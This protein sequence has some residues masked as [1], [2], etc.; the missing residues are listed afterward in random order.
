ML[1]ASFSGG[2]CAGFTAAWPERVGR[3]VLLYPLMDYK[4]R[5]IDDK[6]YWHADYLDSSAA[7]EL[8]TRGFLAHS[9]TFRLGRPLLN[10]VF[11]WR[12]SE[13]LG[14]VA[15]PTLLVHGTGDTFIPVDSSRRAASQLRSAQL[16][17]IENAQH[18][19]AVHEDPQYSQPQTQEW[20][21]YV[22]REVAS[23]LTSP[24]E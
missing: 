18:G 9:P 2:I 10:E 11:T 19:F 3:L 15:A 21:A 12:P 13:V 17:E 1:G 14:R 23:W 4:K 8:V 20:Q 7:G 22:I 24:A 6:P 16:L 5:F